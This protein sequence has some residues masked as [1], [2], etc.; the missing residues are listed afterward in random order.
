MAVLSIDLASKNYRD[1]GFCLL[2]DRV[3]RLRFPRPEELGLDGQPS[4]SVLAGAVARYCAEEGVSVLLIDG[5]QGW[6]WPESPIEHMRLCERVLNTPARTG[7]PGRVK[8][9]TYLPF[10]RFSVDLFRNLRLEDDWSLLVAD[11]PALPGRRWLV[12][13]FPSAAWGMWGLPRLPSKRMSRGIDLEPW[14][15]GLAVMSGFDFPTR[16]SHDEL[17]AAATLQAGQAIDKG[18]RAGVI[19]AGID[20]IISPTDQV[21]E[22]WIALPCVSE[23]STNGR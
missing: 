3:P 16:L 7:T 22:G 13:T 15:R 9:S 1:I 12:E 17:Q 11:W 14:R 2:R 10:V 4:A 21:Y 18:D 19:L 23:D 6:R 8:P 20:P 5:P